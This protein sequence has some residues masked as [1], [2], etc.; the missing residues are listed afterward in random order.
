M[1]FAI[2]SQIRDWE[3]GLKWVNRDSKDEMNRTGF[4]GESIF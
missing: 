3:L 2:T 4:V 1:V